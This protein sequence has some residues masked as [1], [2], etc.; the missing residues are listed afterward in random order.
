MSIYDYPVYT[1]VVNTYNG[2]HVSQQSVN[3]VPIGQRGTVIGYMEGTHTGEDRLLVLFDGYTKAV[4][5]NPR[6]VRKDT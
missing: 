1:R 3:P 2:I 5:K 4:Q 6:F